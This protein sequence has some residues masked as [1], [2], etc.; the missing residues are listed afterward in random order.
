MIEHINDWENIKN[1]EECYTMI[2]Y[3][4]EEL[5]KRNFDNCSHMLVGH[6]ISMM[7]QLRFWNRNIKNE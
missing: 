1:Y 7:G 6:Y 3:T 5:E 4:F 2:L